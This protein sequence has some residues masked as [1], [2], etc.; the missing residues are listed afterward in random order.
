LGNDELRVY[1]EDIFGRAWSKTLPTHEVTVTESL[2]II[3]T[4]IMITPKMIKACIQDMD[5]IQEELAMR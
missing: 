3:R 5:K 2:E 4:R 1:V